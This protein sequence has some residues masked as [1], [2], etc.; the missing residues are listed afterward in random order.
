MFQIDKCEP[1]TV[2]QQIFACRKFPR[3]SRFSADSRIF[4]AREY[5][6]YTV[7]V[8]SFH[9]V[10]T[11]W[12]SDKYKLSKNAC[13]VDTTSKNKLF[14]LY[15]IWLQKFDW[16]MRRHIVVYTLGKQIIPSQVSCSYPWRVSHIMHTIRHLLCI[17]E[18]MTLFGYDFALCFR[19]YLP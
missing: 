7:G 9:W 1:I 5:Y 13:K 10:F 18:S 8:L 12:K 16:L 4:H 19:P 2:E 14:Y 3:I 17:L 6:H 15:I 11:E